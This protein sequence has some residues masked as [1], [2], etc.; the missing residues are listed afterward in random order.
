MGINGLWS[1]LLGVPLGGSVVGGGGVTC[2]LD[3]WMSLIYTFHY[4]TFW[5]ILP[6]LFHALFLL[7]QVPQISTMFCFF[8]D[9]PSWSM[10]L[11][12]N[13]L[14]SSIM[15]HCVPW[16]SL[17]F[18]RILPECSIMFHNVPRVSVTFH[19]ALSHSTAFYLVPW[20]SVTFYHVLSHS[21]PFYMIPL[22]MGMT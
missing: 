14:Q 12:W 3:L 21:M 1:V 19:H 10:A 20:G 22:L 16:V 15:F 11:F 13:V 2:P 7:W 5:N 17:G 9:F 18:H 8:Y 4:R 6:L